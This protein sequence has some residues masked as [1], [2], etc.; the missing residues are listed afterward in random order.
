MPELKKLPAP[1]TRKGARRFVQQFNAEPRAFDA[2][3]AREYFDLQ[4]GHHLSKQPSSVR[5]KIRA[6]F[7]K[8][9]LPQDALKRVEFR[10]RGV[11]NVSAPEKK[12]IRFGPFGNGRQNLSRLRSQIWKP[13]GRIQARQ[14]LEP[15]Q[16]F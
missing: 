11:E 15:D 5:R 9:F 12:A 13:N 1:K 6:K 4:K 3:T 10:E 2:Q 16:T 8:T 14:G 7:G